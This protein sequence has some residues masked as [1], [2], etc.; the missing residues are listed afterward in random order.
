MEFG[1]E[2]VYFLQFDQRFLRL[3]LCERSLLLRA[4][5]RTTHLDH[6]RFERPQGTT[7]CEWRPAGCGFD[8][9]I[10]GSS[11]LCSA[12]CSFPPDRTHSQCKPSAKSGIETW[13]ASNGPFCASNTRKIGISVLL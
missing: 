7:R 11:L 5:D 9:S 12:P 2:L 8:A 13:Q 1:H 4:P 10:P 3:L 6:P